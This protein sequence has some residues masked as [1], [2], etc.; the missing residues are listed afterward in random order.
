MPSDRQ[1]L[2]APTKE[3]SGKSSALAILRVQKSLR[4]SQVLRQVLGLGPGPQTAHK[5]DIATTFRWRG[6]GAWRTPEGVAACR[7]PTY[8][9]GLASHVLFGW[10]NAR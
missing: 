10:E 9:V 3:V 7:S 8:Q 4:M 5:P 1:R 2:S 6:S